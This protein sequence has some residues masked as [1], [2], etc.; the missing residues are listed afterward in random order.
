MS[1][2]VQ[3]ALH[4]IREIKSD[5]LLFYLLWAA[6]FTLPLGTISSHHIRSAGRFGLGLFRNGFQAGEHLFWATVVLAGSGTDS[7]A[8]DRAPV[9]TGSERSWYGIRRKDAL[10]ALLH[11]GGGYSFCN[12][13]SRR[14]DKGLSWR[15]SSEYICCF[16]PIR[17]E[18]LSL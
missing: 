16:A 7:H 1:I 14:T 9:Y 17:A 8:L 4:K 11:G 15:V 5:D 6:F 10:L 2:S 3:T 18:Y 13:R 12:S